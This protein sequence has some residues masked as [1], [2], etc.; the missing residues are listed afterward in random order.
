MSEMATNRAFE[1]KEHG[2]LNDRGRV[3]TFNISHHIF[4]LTLNVVEENPN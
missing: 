3:S 1:I 2:M 4:T